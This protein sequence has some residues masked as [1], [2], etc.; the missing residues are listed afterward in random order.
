MVRPSFPQIQTFGR[1]LIRAPAKSGIVKSG[2]F[3]CEWHK[4]FAG[5]A[6][7]QLLQ[8]ASSR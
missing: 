1:A 7:K 8:P 3:L 5:E 4:K 2:I 6:E